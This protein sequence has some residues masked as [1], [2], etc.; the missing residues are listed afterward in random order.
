MNINYNR[1]IAVL[2]T[3]GVCN[4]NCKYC[5]IDKNPILKDIDAALAESF[6]GDYYFDRIKQYFPH[7]DQLKRVETWG[8][9]PFLHMDRI[10]PLVH[11][12]I[13]HYPYFNAMFSSTN[14]AYDTWFDQFIGLINC[15][16][17]YPNRAF[18][19]ELQL[20]VD[21]PEKINDRNR[22][23][24]VTERCLKNYQKLI[25]YIRAEKWPTNVSLEI[26]LKGTWDLNAIHELNNE[27]ALIDFFQFYETNYLDPINKLNIPHIVVN[28]TV[29][30][31]A[32]P[33]P[34]TKQDGI[35]FKE[36]V[37]KCRIIESKNRIMRY[38]KYYKIITPFC[39]NSPVCTDYQQCHH[40]CGTG[41]FM[42]GFLPNNMVSICHEG[43]AQLVQKYKELAANSPDEVDKVICFDKFMDDQI[44]SL[45]LTDEQYEIY[46]NKIKLFTKFGAGAR[47]AN[48]TCL[49]I[50]LAMAGQIDEAY[51]YEENARYAAA[52]CQNVGA[53]CI[54][55]NYNITGS[56]IMQP[57]DMFKLL[58]N[59]AVEYLMPSLRREI[60]E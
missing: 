13:E 44:G 12:L 35:I 11:K 5:Q 18:H 27:Q 57:D 60:I 59:G 45:C 19:Y 54:K 33:S 28:T 42:M 50:A 29:P 9:E 51:V 34:V 30:N 32:V 7:Q 4:L 3:C 39:C 40:S 47:L 8:G 2:Y 16:A 15:F 48:D 26:N 36:L 25:D 23:K 22:G 53:F 20:S 6:K 21:G 37:Q 56:L 49:I 14:F 58:L 24:G 55:N 46:E 38:F 43:F 10:Y 41:D 31:V 17:Q 52:I 1:E